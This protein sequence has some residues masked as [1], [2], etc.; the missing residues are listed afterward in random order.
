MAVVE[1]ALGEN[2]KS[3]SNC[4]AIATILSNSVLSVS[5]GKVPELGKSVVLDI[6]SSLYIVYMC[7]LVEAPPRVILPPPVA[8][9]PVTEYCVA[10]AGLEANVKVVSVPLTVLITTKS[11]SL[12]NSKGTE[13]AVCEPDAVYC[14]LGE[15]SE[16]VILIYLLNAPFSI[17]SNKLSIYHTF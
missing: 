16:I 7:P 9:A 3:L 5:I 2:F 6:G 12:K 4:C 10:F 8:P 1:T 15:V 13:N 17:S 11:A 14:T